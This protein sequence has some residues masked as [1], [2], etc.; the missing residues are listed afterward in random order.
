MTGSE[1][2][3]AVTLINSGDKEEGIALLC[4]IHQ[5]EP[6]MKLVCLLLAKYINFD[7][8]KLKYLEEA[9]EINPTNNETIKFYKR[10]SIP[11]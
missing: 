9:L 2:D 8:T 4:E 5:K 1:L 11:S 3:R 7:E 10:S 6:R